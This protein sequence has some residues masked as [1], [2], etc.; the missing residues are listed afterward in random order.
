MNI[1]FPLFYSLKPRNQVRI[2]MCRNWSINAKLNVV[3]CTGV[4]LFALVFNLNCTAFS[5]S[6][7]S[8]FF[9]VNYYD[10]KVSTG[11]H[12]S[13]APGFNQF[14]SRAAILELVN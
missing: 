9:N 3:I 2:L 13:W 10:C 1:L 5:E 7:S 12:G 4:T 11:A 14:S 6:E 8:I